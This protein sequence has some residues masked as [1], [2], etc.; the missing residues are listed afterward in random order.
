MP[1]RCP[2]KLNEAEDNDKETVTPDHL[3]SYKITFIFT[4]EQIESV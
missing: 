4:A 2:G 1:S 3:E